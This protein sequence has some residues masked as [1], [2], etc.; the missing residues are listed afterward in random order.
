MARQWKD[1]GDGASGKLVNPGKLF[2]L[3]LAADSV[4]EV[5]YQR[6]K[7]EVLLKVHPLVSFLRFY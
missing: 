7:N 4:R 3:K 1:S 5:N 2:F 6:D